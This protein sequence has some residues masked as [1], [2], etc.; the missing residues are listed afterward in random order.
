[1]LVSLDG[2]VS[3]FLAV[4]ALG[5]L[6]PMAGCG[7]TVTGGNTLPCDGATPVEVLGQDSGY[8]MCEGQWM[9]RPDVVQCAS[10]LP[11][12][13]TCDKEAYGGE[14]TQDSDCTAKPHG[15]CGSSGF[16]G[17][18]CGCQYG[19]VQDSDCAT[20]QVCVCGDPVGRC[21]KASCASDADC[22]DGALCATYITEPGCGGIAFACQSPDDECGGDGDCPSNSQCTLVGDH[23]ECRKIECAIGRPF[24]VEGEARV[25]EVARRDDWCA[26]DVAPRA[27]GL[28]ADVR[29]VLAEEWAR[30][31]QMEHASIAAFARFSMQLLAL[32]APPDL[33]VATHAAMADETEHALACF[34]LASAYAGAPVGPGRLAMEGALADVDLA[35]AV[36]LA[37]REGCVGETVAAVEAAE[38]SRRAEDPAVRAVLAK[39]A[40]DETRHAELAWRFVRWAVSSAPELR[41]AVESEFAA[42][43]GEE[44][45]RPAA[46][47]S[48]GDEAWLAHGVARGTVKAE[49]RRRLID[50][51]VAPAATALLTAR[52]RTAPL[53]PMLLT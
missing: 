2:F 18:Y 26:R 37:I 52:A 7:T 1:M 35:S 48:A 34:A 21:V 51:V 44:R 20:G 38:A 6:V 45:A 24:L 13:L 16:E 10:A 33:L 3:R 47:A 17:P 8:E 39:I 28:A 31:G 53:A 40:E 9:H 50:A 30:S 42:V 41:G 27:D 14:C 12:D 15:S 19:C 43:L 5:P 11:R 49:L 25:A 32:G 23:R 22:A 4:L 36:R 29:R 46:A